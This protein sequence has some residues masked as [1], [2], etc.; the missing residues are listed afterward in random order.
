MRKGHSDEPLKAKIM[1]AEAFIIFEFH[2]HC[3]KEGFFSIYLC[4]ALLTLLAKEAGVVSLR[5]LFVQK[6]E[7]VIFPKRKVLG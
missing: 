3:A 5:G 4:P 2:L 7:I 1:S 6:V